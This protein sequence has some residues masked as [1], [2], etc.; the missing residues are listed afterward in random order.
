M[1]I[2]VEKSRAE[3]VLARIEREAR[4]R[5]LPIIGPEKG[6]VL[7][8]LVRKYEPKRILEVGTLVGYSTIVMGRE[9]GSDAE[10]LTIE[11]DEEEAEIARKN[12]KKARIRPRVRVLVGNAL[13][14]IPKLEGKFDLVFLDAKKSEYLEYLKLVEEKLHKGSVVVAD[15]AGSFAHAMRDYLR[16]VRKSGRYKSKLIRVGW[17]GIEVSVKL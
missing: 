11:I 10:I 12:I 6:K 17:D 9:L 14:L 13:E 4:K 2:E 1:R 7:A 5:Y 3:E 8:E 15:N 16:Y